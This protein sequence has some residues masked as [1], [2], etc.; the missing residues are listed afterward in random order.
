MKSKALSL[1]HLTVGSLPK[2]FDNFQHLINQL[3]TDFD[4]KGVTE[5]RLIEGIT[6]TNNINLNYYVIEHTPTESSAGG[7]LL[8]INKK[9]SY[10]P[11]I[12]RN[13]YKLGYHESIFVEII[14]PKRPN[15]II[16]C[17]YKHPSINIRTF[18]DHYLNPLLETLS[19]KKY[20]KSFLVGDFNIDLL[21]FDTS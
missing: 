6:S 21:K 14:L 5:S 12:D 13:I 11:R 17:I 20:L 7:A 8:Y 19:K 18:N 2:Q 4:S 16:G 3:Q 10:Q 1:F 9:C 15:I